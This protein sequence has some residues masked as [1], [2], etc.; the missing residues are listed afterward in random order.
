MCQLLKELGNRHGSIATLDP[1]KEVKIQDLKKGGSGEFESFTKSIPAIR[2]IRYGDGAVVMA[3]KRQYPAMG[4]SFH[5]SNNII[6]S[7]GR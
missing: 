1:I 5:N 7:S 2:A 4:D 3:M 6:K